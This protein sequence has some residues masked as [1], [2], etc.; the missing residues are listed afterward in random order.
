MLAT[1]ALFAMDDAGFIL[2]SY[3]ITLTAIVTYAGYLVRRA[4]RTGRSARREDLPWT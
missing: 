1:L 2:A 4:R 3:A